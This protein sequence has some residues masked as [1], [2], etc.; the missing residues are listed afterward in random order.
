MPLA[1]H[2]SARLDLSQLI[3]IAGL[4]GEF[5]GI[6][7]EAQGNSAALASTHFMYDESTGSSSSLVMFGRN[8]AADRNSR[9]RAGGQSNQW[10]AY[11]PMLALQTPDPALGLP[12]GT[13]SQPTIL[14]RNTT[15]VN[16]SANITLSW[17][18]D[19]GR[20]QA[21]LPQ[22]GLAPFATQQF[23]IAAMQKQLGIPDDAHW[24]MATLSGMASRNELIAVASSSDVSGRYNLATPFSDNVGGS[25]AGGE[26]RVDTNHNHIIAVT[27]SGQKPADALLTLH[28]DNGGKSYKMQQT[29]QPGDQMWVDLANLTRH[30]IPDRDGNVFPATA[31]V[32]T[33]DIQE[34]STRNGEL[35]PG[36]LALDTSFGF[37]AIPATQKCCGYSD[38]T[39]N[40]DLFDFLYG[41]TED[42]PGNIDATQSCNGSLYNISDDFG[43]WWSENTA[44]AS[45]TKQNVR[46]VGAGRTYA[47]AFGEVYQDV[48]GNCAFYPWQSQAPVTVQVPTS[49]SVLSVT[50]LPNGQGL[51][52]GCSGLANY[53]IMVD[54]KYQVLDQNGAAIASANMTPY[55]QGT[56]FSGQPYSGN[57]GPSGFTNS[58]LTTAADGTFHDVPFGA[59]ANGAFSV[60]TNTQNISMIMPDGSTPAVRS[61]TFTLTGKTAGHGTLS[62]GSDISATR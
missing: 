40:P 52:F 20:G 9:Q 6:R 19:S 12:A 24:A 25:F 11:A 34:V 45:V 31:A 2:Q 17:R 30:P 59:C 14:V 37:Q 48:G 46:Q 38:I 22:F 8:P 21:K 49:L 5:G 18:G 1:P 53:G 7:F 54:I 13:E 58:T 29:I 56:G 3:G 32:G 36:A 28:Y 57:I 27:N 42:Y 51:N 62:N 47:E 60:A 43:D 4:S 44:V 50:V 15:P 39:W 23:Q 10:T 61:Q 41:S 33:Y 55:E 26:W 16:V 35:V